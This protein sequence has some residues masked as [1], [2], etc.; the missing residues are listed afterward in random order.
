MPLKRENQTPVRPV[1]GFV[2]SD[3]CRNLPCSQKNAAP[4]IRI[5]NAWM[6]KAEGSRWANAVNALVWDENERIA[7][8]FHSSDKLVSTL[9]MGG[10][11]CESACSGA[12]RSDSEIKVNVVRTLFFSSNK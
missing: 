3:H 7:F 8:L 1:G 9:Q 4:K 2:C 10:L 12:L 5:S 6:R 11:S